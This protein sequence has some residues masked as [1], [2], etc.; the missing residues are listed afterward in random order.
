MVD[1]ALSLQGNAFRTE[2]VHNVYFVDVPPDAAKDDVRAVTV[3]SAKRSLSWRHIG[4][5]SPLRTLYEWDG[6]VSFLREVLELPVL[7]RDD[8]PDGAC[9][10]MFYDEDDELGWHFDNSE[11]SVTVMLAPSEAGGDYEYVPAMR[12]AEDDNVTALRAVLAGEPDLVRALRDRAGHP[13]V[14]SRPL[15]AT[16][17]HADP[18]GEQPHERR[19]RLCQCPGSPAGAADPRLFYGPGD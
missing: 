4:S 9:S 5:V 16:P 2:A 1:E 3:R 7:Y 10:V 15:L 12:S 14:V 6:L 17:C 18:P 11:F 13:D 8:D 19:P